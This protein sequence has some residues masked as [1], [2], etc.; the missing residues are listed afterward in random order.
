MEDSLTVLFLIVPLIGQY[1]SVNGLN[2]LL[3]PMLFIP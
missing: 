3:I 1:Y 2:S